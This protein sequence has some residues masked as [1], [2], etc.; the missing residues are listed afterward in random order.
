MTYERFSIEPEA[1]ASPAEPAISP[2]LHRDPRIHDVL[3][4]IEFLEQLRRPRRFT[5]QQW[6]ELLK[7]LRHVAE[8]WLDIAL[9]CDWSLLDLFGSPAVLPGRA[10]LLGVAPIL[11]GRS[12]ESIDHDR[13]V[14][15]NRLG[16]ASVFYRSNH[17]ADR[18]DRE[19][20]W[21]VITKEE[22]Q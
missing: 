16:S 20:I 22:S 5:E 15:A 19:L 21:D 8:K 9:V 18:H 10:G 4:A 17:G 3:N 13:I 6:F 11:R 7:D 14:I 1:F 2:P 12:I